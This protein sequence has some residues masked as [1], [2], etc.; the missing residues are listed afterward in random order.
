MA[1]YQPLEMTQTFFVSPS[2]LF[3]QSLP[4]VYDNGQPTLQLDIRRVEGHWMP[5][6]RWAA[7]GTAR[8]PDARHRR[9][10]HRRSA[11]RAIADPTGKYA[12]RRRAGRASSWTPSTGAYSRPT[13]RYLL[14]IGLLRPRPAW[15]PS[16]SYDTGSFEFQ[17][18]FMQGHAQQLDDPRQRRLGL[19]HATRPTT[20]SSPTAA[21]SIS[22]ATRSTSWSAA[23]SPSVR[24]SSAARSP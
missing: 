19:R 7:G 11:T 2:L 12:H 8:R 23:S 14:V 18:T 9:C 5:A 17:H 22:P 15:G 21:C 6:W 13:A 16:S 1:F 4:Y 3:Q 10:R 24:C 20:T